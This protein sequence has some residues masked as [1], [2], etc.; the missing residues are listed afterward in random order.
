MEPRVLERH[1]HPISRR[2]IDSDVL[3]VLYRLINGNF[4]AYLV[5]GGV[6]DL[7]LARRPKDFD[8]GTSA[9]PHQVRALF[10]NSRLIGR[11]FRLVHVFF[12]P[13]NIEVATFRSRGEEPLDGEALIRQDNTFGTPEED[14]LRRDFTVNAL[15]YDP[16]AFHVIDYVGGLEDLQAHLIRTVGEPEIRMREDPVRMMRAVRFAAKLGFAIEPATREAILKHRGELLK[17]SVPRLVEEI[18][19]TLSS[20]NAEQALILME[21]LGLL[22]VVLPQLSAHMRSRPAPLEATR[23]VRNLAA[24]S[25][26][27]TDR[28]PLSHALTLAALFLDQEM[29]RKQRAEGR[30][31]GEVGL[32]DDLR[33]RG[34]A[35]GDTEH[36]RLLIE[37]F[38]RMLEP[39]RKTRSLIRRPY[40]AQARMLYELAAPHYTEDP[41]VLDRFLADPDNY[42]SS[43]SGSGSA[44][45]RPVPSQ[46]RRRRRRSRRG[47]RRSGHGAGNGAASVAED[48]R[49]TAAKT[50]SS[51]SGV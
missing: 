33:A 51:Q 21:E 8:I 19:R 37:A 42:L 24:L 27:N 6:R 43:L 36:M 17:A 26:H 1:A 4:V 39:G 50:P 49:Q 11:R 28:N 9:H 35:R 47:R 20:S 3:K 31:D 13:R 44:E 34:F 25:R 23:T 22:E 15:F 48:H 2:H 40:F 10:R 32:I 5:G 46:H 45:T 18:F 14:A 41:G 12:G 16:Q 7:M 30:R 38:P 29:E